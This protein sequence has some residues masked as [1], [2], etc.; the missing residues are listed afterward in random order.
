MKTL[1][2][3]GSLQMAFHRMMKTLEEMEKLASKKRQ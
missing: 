3:D 2:R 1:K